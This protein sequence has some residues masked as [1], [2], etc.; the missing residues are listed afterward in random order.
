MYVNINGDFGWLIFLLFGAIVVAAAIYGW[1][2]E[3]KRRDEIFVWATKNRFDYCGEKDYSF[4]KKFSQ[5]ECFQKG[6]NHYSYN[7][8]KGS[9]SD[10][11]FLSFDYHYE[12]VT[13]SS[14]GGRRTHHH[15]FSGVLLMSD[16]TLDPLF[17]RPETILDKFTEF[18]G[19]NDIDF[20]SAEFS[21][22]FYVKAEDKK[23]AYDVLHQRM[24]EFLLKS[25]RY[26]VQFSWNSV[27]FWRDSKFSLN[28]IEGALEL[29]KGIFDRL[30]D[31]VIIQQREKYQKGA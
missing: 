15:H 5:Y 12:T 3:S 16:M 19:W 9:W 31:Y 21:K 6:E 26:Q 20:E 29:A 27:L 1:Y 13:H 14:K 24:M 17:I 30:P 7:T 11:P 25:P 8:V 4:D 28:D 18:V 10:R 23:W 2:A 22:A